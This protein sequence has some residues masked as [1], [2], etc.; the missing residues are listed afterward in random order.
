MEEE[1]Q[2]DLWLQATDIMERTVSVKRH[3]F[4][5]VAHANVTLNQSLIDRTKL[6]WGI[7][8][9]VTNI[10]ASNQIVIARYHD[11]WHVE[12]SFRMA[13]SDLQS[14]P[15]FHFKQDAIKAHLLICIMALAVGKYVE[16]KTKKS[17][18]I[19]LSQLKQLPDARIE[20]ISTKEQTNWRADI[21]EET[22]KMLKDLGCTY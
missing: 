8:G 19:V 7:K 22:K 15:I 14:R 1:F 18:Q 9:Y 21:S 6:L 2:I 4:L 12:Q 13:K 3:R 11:L 5:T 17:L 10:D 20:H 16:G